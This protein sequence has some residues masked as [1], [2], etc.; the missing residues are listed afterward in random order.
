MVSALWHARSLTHRPPRRR[1][2]LPAQR[3][4]RGADAESSSGG[5]SGSGL[6]PLPHSQLCT[7]PIPDRPMLASTWTSL[8]ICVLQSS[9][10][11]LLAPFKPAPPSLLH[12]FSHSRIALVLG[13]DAS[14]VET[15]KREELCVAWSYNNSRVRRGGGQVSGPPGRIIFELTFLPNWAS[16]VWDLPHIS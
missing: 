2:S 15:T 6:R 10:N 7:V 9:I 5:R 11:L 3:F 14:F 16:P 4:T 13:L 1:R 12:S 8:H